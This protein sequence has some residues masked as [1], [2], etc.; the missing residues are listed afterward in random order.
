MKKELLNILI[1]PQCQS[2]LALEATE[3]DENSAVKQGTLAC[4]ENSHTYPIVDYVP[5]FVSSEYYAESFGFQWNEFASTQLDYE[6]TSEESRSIYHTGQLAQVRNLIRRSSLRLD[7]LKETS[8]ASWYL[9]P[10]AAW[11]ASQMFAPGW[12]LMWWR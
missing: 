11:V 5:R 6:P 3:S 2:S 4:L 1:C 10:A 9:T 12:G 7:Y 8:E